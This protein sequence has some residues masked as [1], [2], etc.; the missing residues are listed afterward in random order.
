LKKKK[1]IRRQ[2]A[3][4]SQIYGSPEIWRQYCIDTVRSYLSAYGRQY[5]I[6]KITIHNNHMEC[7]Y[8]KTGHAHRTILFKIVSEQYYEVKLKCSLCQGCVLMSGDMRT[9]EMRVS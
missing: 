5:S 4:T 8:N 9:G 6:G 7:K 3:V 1:T 2:N